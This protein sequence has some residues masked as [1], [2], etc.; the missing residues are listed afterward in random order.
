M[1][2]PP[3]RCED[4]GTVAETRPYGPNG[5]NVCFD[6]GTK[7]EEAMKRAFERRMGWAA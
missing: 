5:E 1:A 4:C 7:D 6:C 2:Q 3:G